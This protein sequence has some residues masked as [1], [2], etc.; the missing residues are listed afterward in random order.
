M[1][2]PERPVFNNRYEI[3]RRIGRGGMA[4]VYLARDQLLDRPVAIKV[5]FPEFATDPSFVERFRREAQSAANLNHPN[6]VSVFDW[7][8]QGGTYFIVMEY[9]NGRSLA[10]ILRKDGPLLPQ[11]AAEV[12]ADVAG[13]LGFA[14]RNAVVHRDVKPANILVSPDGAVKVTDFGI[15]RVLNAPTEQGLTQAGAVMGTAT[16]FSPEQAQGANPDPRSDLYSLGIVMYEMVAGRPPFSG[17][18]PVAI[19][20]KQVHDQPL[21]PS[22]FAPDLP[23]AYEAITLRL[24]AKSPSSRYQSADDLRVD[25]RR[26]R[27]GRLSG[28][29]PLTGSVPM[30]P[31]GAQAGYGRGPAGT[32]TAAVPPIG[33]GAGGPGVADGGPG[34]PTRMA[35]V[36]PSM[37][38][39]QE[40]YQSTRAVPAQQPPSSAAGPY[41]DP[42][43]PRRTG[44]FVLVVLV[45]VALVVGLVFVL[46]RVLDKSN[47][48]TEKVLVQ[49]V[50]QKTQADAEAIL[51]G[52]GL[53]PEVTV[54]ANPQIPA[55]IVFAQDPVAGTSVDKDSVVKLQVAAGPTKVTVPDFTNKPQADAIDAL[56]KLKLVPDVTSEPSDTVAAGLV[57]SQDP[58]AGEV[59][60]G[61]TVKL[62]VSLGKGQIAIT[63]VA[64]LDQADAVA[65]LTK[66][67]FNAK[68]QSEPSDTVAQNKVIRTDPPAGT[69]ADKDSVVTIF[70]SS[71]AAPVVVPNVVGLS[72]SAATDQ[73]QAAGLRRQVVTVDVPF[74]SPKDGTVIGQ[75]PQANDQV[76]KNSVVTIQVA[77]AGPAP[78]TTTTTAPQ[79]TTT[80]TVKPTTTT[81]AGSTTTA[82]P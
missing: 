11:R 47:T 1:S 36:S 21:P 70:V 55:G 32:P 67:G 10:D 13:A 44:I 74:G 56:S 41:L 59:D 25:L 50:L 35:P 63:N 58:P 73:L 27:E 71:G 12:A 68:V 54:V 66:Q 69:M 3:H 76:P 22:R 42:E 33:M 5:L 17:E 40:A 75:N 30:Q 46:L 61:S 53:T 8:R 6:I 60:E 38:R 28:G 65:Q 29:D 7:G 24:L 77:K 26:F 4:D 34:D 2:T 37:A 82:K 49:N 64:G 51:K 16:Y 9:V 52:Q 20:Y 72:E 39:A 80:T 14:H 48:A 62:V 78:T 23:M 79:T 31:S 43:P 81:A 18:N 57:I 15:A 45:A 19:A